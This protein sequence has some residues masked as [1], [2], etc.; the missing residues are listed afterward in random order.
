[1]AK[2]PILITDA[3]V[4]GGKADVAMLQPLKADLVVVGTDVTNANVAGGV[5]P[6]T[7]AVA[8]A[9]GLGGSPG[10]PA[11]ALLLE[12]GDG[13]LLEDGSFLLLESN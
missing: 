11:S 6:V 5:L 7:T 13:L 3:A 1:M 4:S 12:N 8:N 9:L 2:L 10:G